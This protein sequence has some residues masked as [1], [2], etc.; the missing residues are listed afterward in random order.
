MFSSLLFWTLH[1]LLE[2]HIITRLVYL[3]HSANV[4]KYWHEQLCVGVHNSRDSTFSLYRSG[5]ELLFKTLSLRIYKRNKYM[6]VSFYN[7]VGKLL[8]WNSISIFAMAVILYI[9]IH[10]YI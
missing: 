1:G 6:Y 2:K 8:A 3:W 10:I 4:N 7:F 9:Y 5:M